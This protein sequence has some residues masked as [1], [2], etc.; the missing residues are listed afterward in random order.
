MS[1][2]SIANIFAAPGH[3]HVVARR[4]GTKA[5]CGGPILCWDCIQELADAI[6][7]YPER[8][9]PF[10]RTSLADHRVLGAMAQLRR[11]QNKLSRDL[12][13]FDPLRSRASAAS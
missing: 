1:A 7:R 4:D 8:L 12:D 2:P 11:Q 5:H 9:T 13:Q 3:G 10:A 6:C